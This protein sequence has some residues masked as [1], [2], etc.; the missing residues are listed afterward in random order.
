MSDRAPKPL[1]GS[2]SR[3]AEPL[4]PIKRPRAFAA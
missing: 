4:T 2:G 3:S 1:V